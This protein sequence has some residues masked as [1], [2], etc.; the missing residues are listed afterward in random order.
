MTSGWIIDLRGVCDLSSPKPK[1]LPTF[2]FEPVFHFKL[3]T[4][5]FHKRYIFILFSLTYFWF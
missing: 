2:N 3:K 5:F 4:S 1:Q